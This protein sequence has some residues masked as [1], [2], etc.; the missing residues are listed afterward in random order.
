MPPIDYFV[1]PN[2]IGMD[3]RG[4][5]ADAETQQRRVAHK[6]KERHFVV[7]FNVYRASRKASAGDSTSLRATEESRYYYC[8]PRLDHHPLSA[9]S[10]TTKKTAGL[11]LASD[12]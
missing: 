3:L 1:M 2:A 7:P 4:D 9:P 8:R 6:I 10:R 5:R 12:G 11:L